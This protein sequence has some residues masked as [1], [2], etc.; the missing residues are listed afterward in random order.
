M[1]GNGFFLPSALIRLELE[2]AVHGLLQP[3]LGEHANDVHRHLLVGVWSIIDHFLPLSLHLTVILSRPILRWR[4]VKL[5]SRL[6]LR[7]L[8]QVPKL[9]RLLGARVH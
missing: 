2:Y 1:Y 6:H 4:N 3:V 5:H 8:W 9:E 7:V